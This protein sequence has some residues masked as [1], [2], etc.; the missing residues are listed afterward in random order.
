NPRPGHARRSSMWAMPA[1]FRVTVPLRN[2]P[3]TSGRHNHVRWSRPQTDGAE[4]GVGHPRQRL[5]EPEGLAPAKCCAPQLPRQFG[6]G[7]PERSTKSPGRQTAYTHGRTFCLGDRVE[8][9]S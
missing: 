7:E 6:E 8:V 2:T 5:T 4:G 3:A 1:S 9:T